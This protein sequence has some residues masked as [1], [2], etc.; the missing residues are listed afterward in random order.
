[1]APLAPAARSCAA[2]EELRTPW[3]NT[4]R[5]ASLPALL[6]GAYIVA[7][8]LPPCRLRLYIHSWLRLRAQ[9]PT[10]HATRAVHA[11]HHH[12]PF[13]YH[14]APP[15]ALFRRALGSPFRP[16]AVNAHSYHT[17]A[18]HVPGRTLLPPLHPPAYR[19][20]SCRFARTHRT[21]HNRLRATPPD[22][23]APLYGTPTPPRLPHTTLPTTRLTT[24]AGYLPC[25]VLSA[26]PA[27]GR[28]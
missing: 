1:M 20:H 8:C 5:R 25:W 10:L 6:Y 28:V 14:I 4:W 17:P 15:T 16:A 11:C 13:C 27:V 23:T 26:L 21:C 22:I 3:R 24:T 7:P 2:A 19:H 12:P 18:H 9:P